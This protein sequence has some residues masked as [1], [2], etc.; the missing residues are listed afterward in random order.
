MSTTETSQRRG[1]LVR[2]TEF[3][4]G[5]PKLVLLVAGLAFVV[6]GLLGS[7]VP[8]RLS[9]GGFLDPG[10]ESSRAADELAREFGVSQMQLILAVDTERGVT[11]PAARAEVD[12]LVAVLRADD[13]VRSVTTPAEG[14]ASLVSRDGRT[15]LVVAG[16]DGDD[17]LAQRTARDLSGELTGERD[18]V[19]VTAGGQAMAFDEMNTTAATD[20]ALAEGI[21]IPL[22]FLL[23]VWFLRSALA[24]AVPVVVGILAIVGTT[25]VL[26]VLTFLTDLSVFALNI[27]TALG[28]ALAIDYSLLLI[29]RYREEI[30]RDRTH[31]EALAA[32]MRHGGRAVV[33]SGVIVAT[34]L[35]GL[36][37]FP[38]AFLRSIGL[39]GVAVVVLSIVLA[40]TCVPALLAV[41]GPRMSKR[42]VREAVPAEATR[43]FKVA[44]AVQRRPALFAL[45]VFALLLVAGA[46]VLDLRIGLPD[47]RVLS[48]D[49]ESRRVGDRIREG[50]DQNA[51]GTVHIL[52]EPT[53]PEQVGAYAA[54]LSSVSE[55]TGVGGSAGVF[56]GGVRVGDPT[57]PP[58]DTGSTYLAVAT[59]HNPYSDAARDQLDALKAV[60][61][62][63]PI[64]VGG[65]AQQTEDTAAGIADGFVLALPW[66]VLTTAL[67]LFL[68][69]GSILL[70]LKAL[71]LN[72][73]SLAATFGALVWVFQ[74]GHLGGLGTDAL[75]FTV[76][77]VP[78]LLFCVAFGL[79]MD[80][81]VF[82]LSRFTEEWERSAGTRADVDD[83][84]AV[85]LARSG[86]VVTAAALL[87]AVV[88]A[89]IATSGVS[90][91]RALG[92]GLALAVLVDATLVRMVLVPAFM[93]V[94]GT[95]NWWSPR[96]LDP[97]LNRLRIR[98]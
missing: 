64:L 26:Y 54:R 72:T 34:A 96:F 94:A 10:A 19:R 8:D 42:P 68:L 20:L 23:L 16:I 56:V 95:A 22:T 37:L 83:A 47:D 1:V 33:F 3:C 60:D 75:G 59:G 69:T 24:A 13:R 5:A 9:A 41:F 58:S 12:R 90:I 27:T 4:A 86:R 51:T 25:A 32:A 52:L 18:G 61:A 87:M 55:V 46:P 31:A 38:M 92:V 15:A 85:G 82:L 44:R 50:F 17:N 11:D 57:A 78:V 71:V 77:T 53:T 35:I 28:L 97:V 98:E 67:L 43:L 76:A 2:S 74:Q 93:R 89:G 81:E 30:S 48:T 21:A 49:A 84:V 88:F 65:L 6:F 7:Q 29:G 79:S 73:I 14:G 91:M 80:Y 45:P 70:P 62:P 40:L 66:I 63:A 36:W 39:A